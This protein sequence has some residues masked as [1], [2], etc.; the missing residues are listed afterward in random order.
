[1]TDIH[2]TSGT[3]GAANLNT[4]GLEI[5]RITTGADPTA[6]GADPMAA[7]KNPLVAAAV[8]AAVPD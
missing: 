5:E 4:R 2:S 7:I 6:T 1:L 3:T 8:P